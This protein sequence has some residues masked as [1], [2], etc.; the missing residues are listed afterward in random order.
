LRFDITYRDSAGSGNED[1]DGD[2]DE[3][4]VGGERRE[5]KKGKQ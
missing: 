3:K 5:K 4:A 1:D 2:G